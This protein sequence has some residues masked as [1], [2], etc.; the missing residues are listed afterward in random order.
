MMITNDKNTLFVKNQLDSLLAVD[1]Q[2]WRY[3][4]SQE[5]VYGL[6]QKLKACNQMQTLW[7][8]IQ[9]HNQMGHLLKNVMKHTRLT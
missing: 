2:T 3:R 8:L 4:D 9:M 6:K 5:V 7:M 1:Y